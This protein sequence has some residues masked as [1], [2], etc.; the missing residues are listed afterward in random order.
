MVLASFLDLGRRVFV[1]DLQ[2]NRTLKRWCMW[3]RPPFDLHTNV[4]VCW[5]GSTM[6]VLR[7]NKMMMNTLMI[8]LKR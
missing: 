2:S 4:L 7:M 5:I 6:M 3:A 1:Y 8:L